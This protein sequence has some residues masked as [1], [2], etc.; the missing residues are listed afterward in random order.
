MNS[1]ASILE[2]KKLKESSKKTKRLD[3]ISSNIVG[4]LTSIEEKD[5]CYVILSEDMGLPYQYTGNDID[6]IVADLDIAYKCFISNKFLIKREKKSAFRAFIRNKPSH[7]W[8]VIDV[9]EPN[10]YKGLTKRIVQYN[11][12]NRFLN[13]ISGL[14]YSPPV[15]IAA[16]KM[17]KYLLEGYVHSYSQLINLNKFWNDLTDTNKTKAYQLLEISQLNQDQQ[18][19]IKEFI[20]SGNDVRFLEVEFKNRLKLLRLIRHKNRIVYGGRINNHGLYRAPIVLTQLIIS[21]LF[22][23]KNNPWPAIAIVGNDG[24]GKTTICQKIINDLFKVDPL[25]IVMRASDPWLPG[26]LYIRKRLLNKMTSWKNL[27]KHRFICW[28]FGWIG[29]LGDFIDRWIK[30][31]IGMGWANAGYGFVLFERYPTD[32]LRGEYEGPSFSLYP[33]EKFFPMPDLVILLDV[34][35]IISLER[36]AADNHTYQEM[37]NK[38]ANYLSLIQEINP[39]IVIP[40]GMTIDEVSNNTTDALWQRANEKQ[41]KDFRSYVFPAKWTPTV[42]KL[43]GKS[44]HRKQKHG[45]K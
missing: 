30:Y 4:A 34:D 33:L 36:K 25:H 39:S 41:N 7:K 3:G 45:F 11:L 22:K 10:A 29:E 18:I 43:A 38:R 9:E 13:K 24:S 40:A 19:S 42:R 12:E 15:G 37:S 5:S 2:L 28:V 35:E 14:T 1:L 32:R 20:K 23:K 44:K 31:K 27:K 21:I 16:Y 8:V 6:I 26:W 17:S